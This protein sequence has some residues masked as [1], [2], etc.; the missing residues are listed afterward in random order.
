VADFKEMTGLTRK[1]VIPLLELLDQRGVTRRIGAKR[2]I[3]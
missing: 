3:L 1:Y 2:E